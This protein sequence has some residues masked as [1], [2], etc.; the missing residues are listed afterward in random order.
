MFPCDYEATPADPTLTY[1]WFSANFDELQE[2]G[3]TGPNGDFE[4]NTTKGFLIASNKAGSEEGQ[5]TGAKAELVSPYINGIAGAA[6]CFTFWS[7]ISSGVSN[8]RVKWLCD[9]SV[10]VFNCI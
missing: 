10:T 6:H 8:V 1:A 2:M 4:G 3:L 5:I 9:Q 7:Y